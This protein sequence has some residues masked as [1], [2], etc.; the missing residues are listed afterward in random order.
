MGKY[1]KGEWTEAYTFVKLLGEGKVH[2]ADEFLNKSEEYYPILKIILDTINKSYAR[3]QNRNLVQ[4]INEKGNI[5]KEIPS[6]N[7]IKIANE[8]LKYIQKG[9]KTFEIPTLTNFLKDLK[10]TKFKSSSRKKDDFKMEICDLNTKIQKEY[11]FSIKSE[12]GSPATILNASKSTNFICKIE[13]ISPEKVREINEINNTTNKDWVKKRI[14][15]IY[16]DYESNEYSVNFYKTQD[17]IFGKNLRLIDSNMPKIIYHVLVEFYRNKGLNGVK[18]LTEKVTS[19]N[20][21]NLDDNEKNLFYKTKMIALIKAATLGMM[22][23]KEWDTHYSV[24]GGILTVK[25]SGDIL[26]HHIF[27]NEKSL[28]EYLYKNTKLETASTKRYKIAN[29]STS[30]EK[31]YYFPL[32]LQIRMK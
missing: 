1:N 11:T 14:S 9:Q 7:F 16:T 32:N 4:I 28:G 20:P 18:E 3:K 21:L 25:K 15:K 23:S 26:C 17:P 24:T 13:N 29:I 10:I 8:S 31:N 12:L 30:D 19:L 2:A 22:P 5:E 6:E 27:Y